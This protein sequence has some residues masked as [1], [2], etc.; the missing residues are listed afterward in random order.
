MDIKWIILKCHENK[1]TKMKNETFQDK[2]LLTF[3]AA[4]I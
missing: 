1:I 4:P 2:K 3:M